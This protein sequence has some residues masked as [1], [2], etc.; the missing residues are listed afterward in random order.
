MHS[1]RARR[2]DAAGAPSSSPRTSDTA[3]PSVV[4][5][6]WRHNDLRHCG[7]Q[8]ASAD[9]STS[10]QNAAHNGDAPWIFVALVPLLIAIVMAELSEGGIDA[11]AIALLDLGSVLLRPAYR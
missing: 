6:A 8:L 4:D 5:P 7:V 2:D 9:P 10:T 11:K 1:R 3:G